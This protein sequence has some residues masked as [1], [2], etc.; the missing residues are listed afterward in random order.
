MIINTP[1]RTFKLIS[2]ETVSA[3]LG[4]RL[5]Q[6]RLR[7]NLR[8]QEL[9]D[10]TLSSLSSVRR[11]ES[12]GQGTIEFLVRVA[13]ALQC[14]D[15]LETLFTIVTQSIAEAERS[16]ALIKRRRARLVSPSSQSGTKPTRKTQASY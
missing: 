16:E 15:Q 10:M 9:A 4:M 6:I 2:P 3:E 13:Q 12:Q 5:K 8:Q 7:Q 1:I 14:V 11:L